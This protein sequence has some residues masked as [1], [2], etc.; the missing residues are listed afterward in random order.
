[1]TRIGYLDC[2][3]GISG[4]MLLGAMLHAGLD[5]DAL[6]AEL[7]K[8][9]VDG[10]TLRNEA[11]TRAGIAATKA[12]VDLAESPQPHRR[13]PDIL[14]I[15]NGSSLHADDRERAS[16]VFQ[17]LAEAEARVHRTSV[18]EIGFHEVGAL[19]A[20]VDVAGGVIGMRL[21]GI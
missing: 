12:H 21:L 7:A 11:V 9:G 20:I 1:M 5:A 6:R 3:S 16:A 14:K 15:I 8:L 18:D 10:W 13:L 4:D 19:D 17:R 2:F